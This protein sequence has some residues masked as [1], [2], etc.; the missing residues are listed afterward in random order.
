MLWGNQ[1]QYT[2]LNPR[3]QFLLECR[4]VQ[5]GILG[6]DD[7][8]YADLRALPSGYRAAADSAQ[9]LPYL[10]LY[11][12]LQVTQSD[13]DVAEIGKRLGLPIKVND[14]SY[15]RE[16]Y[17]GQTVRNLE[18]F[19]S[20]LLQAHRDAIKICRA[21][22]AGVIQVIHNQVSEEDLTDIFLGVSD[23]RAN[24]K[25][26]N[27]FYDR[28]LDA[29]AEF[30]R[31]SLVSSLL[32]STTY[33][34]LFVVDGRAVRQTRHPYFESLVV[35]FDDFY[36][37]L[38]TDIFLAAIESRAMATPLWRPRPLN[39]DFRRR[40]KVYETVFVQFNDELKILPNPS[41]LSEAA[42]V[43]QSRPV[44]RLRAVLDEWLTQVGTAT[45]ALEQRIRRDIALAN[46]DIQTLRRIRRHKESPLVFAIKA[47]AGQI[48]LVGN[49]VSG[50]ESCVWLYEQQLERRSC[51]VT[52]RDVKSS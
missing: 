42:E 29:L 48:P 40:E 44:K 32:Q 49:V 12:E 10:A 45:D 5:E 7:Y 8:V 30:Y 52:L 4:A 20:L 36:K 14:P 15:V 39:V 26:F 23:V 47:V 16:F 41:S 51:W 33:D 6:A 1:H 37:R 31:L 35:Q 2:I 38:V 22:R 21:D 25:V 3:L 50:V 13:V 28:L 19:D 18:L 46:R 17:F 9:I 34:E 11:P 24:L 27:F 43:S